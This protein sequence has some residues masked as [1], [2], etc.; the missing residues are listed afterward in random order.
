MMAAAGRESHR[1]TSTERTLLSPPGRESEEGAE[2]SRAGDD[3]SV[4]G[5]DPAGFGAAGR[6]A[7]VGNV[8]ALYSDQ[9]TAPRAKKP[10][11]RGCRK[12]K[13]SP[14]G[15][16]EV[17]AAVDTTGGDVP[18][19]ASAV[20][21][22]GEK[23][24]E[25]LNAPS[26]GSPAPVAGEDG[27]LDGDGMESARTTSANKPATR[28]RSQQMYE[29]YRQ[30]Q[31]KL[32]AKR[33]ETATSGC[34][35]APQLSSKQKGRKS[36]EGVTSD[37]LYK[38]FNKQME[39]RERLAQE[40]SKK[41]SFRPMLPTASSRL[42]A[43]MAATTPVEGH[44]RAEDKSKATAEAMYKE[45]TFSPDTVVTKALTKKILAAKG[46]QAPVADRLY[47]TPET[48][49]A[50]AKSREEARAAKELATCTFRP[51]TSGSS[52]RSS[53]GSG[54]RDS[55]GSKNAHDRLFG[56][57]GEML[58]SKQAKREELATK[59]SMTCT[60]SPALVAKHVPKG[61]KKL[62]SVDTEN[63]PVYERLYSA[64]GRAQARDAFVDPE[65]TFQPHFKSKSVSSSPRRRD[66]PEG[67]R[68]DEMYKVGKERQAS[69]A[70]SQS[71][72]NYTARFRDQDEA[73]EMEL[74]TFQP[75]VSSS[76]NSRF[77]A[78]SRGGAV[79]DTLYAKHVDKA[80]ARERV[81]EEDMKACTFS[82]QLASHKTRIGR[83]LS[84][85]RQGP[86]YE[87]L[88]K[89]ASSQRL[90]RTLS[91]EHLQSQQCPFKPQLATRPRS[92]P[93][94]SSTM[95]APATTIATTGGGQGETGAQSP[96]DASSDDAAAAVAE[97]TSDVDEALPSVPGS[98]SSVQQS[99]SP[100]AEG[101]EPHAV[102]G[103]E[104]TVP[105]PPPPQ[106]GDEGE[107]EQ[108]EE[109]EREVYDY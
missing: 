2:R 94:T 5:G 89:E 51:D 68:V 70:R 28:E 14:G 98:P 81:R 69:T 74:C 75:D 26:A 17:A 100:P 11:K 109:E 53:A 22:E 76:Q 79:F 60:F 44:K 104:A 4:F 40:E 20:A 21:S 56:L 77:K 42:A 41:L 59:E 58:M 103:D 87:E 25:V 95:T 3:E 1:S 49:A 34:T 97:G 96:L 62:L 71:P 45:C 84:P 39:K 101:S 83:S 30:T 105:P 8:E 90:S 52:K 50:L 7:G 10:A 63:E 65:C 37:H 29:K 15:P 72:R 18:A 35:F 64:R 43:K 66:N 24:G 55:A 85:Q 32:R 48:Q 13:S 16:S 12:N 27:G 47:A 31:E 80:N 67:S 92:P 86:V 54:R 33:D 46:K 91:A 99:S 108:E 73:K 57:H 107:D 23:G 88:Y 106:V 102:G 38:D 78:G 82:P 19:T 6:E 9:Q 93:A 36:E 61:G